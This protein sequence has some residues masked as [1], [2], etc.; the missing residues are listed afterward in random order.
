MMFVTIGYNYKSKLV[1]CSGNVNS[2]KYRQL[3]EKAEIV[4]DLNQIYGEGQ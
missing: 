4:N 3:V 2:L 1:I